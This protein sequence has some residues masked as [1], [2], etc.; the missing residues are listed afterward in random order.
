MRVAAD[1]VVLAN[2]FHALDAVK[3]Q[4]VAD[5]ID[6]GVHIAPSDVDVLNWFALSRRR[7]ILSQQ[8]RISGDFTR[9][10]V[11]ESGHILQALL[12]WLHGQKTNAFFAERYSAMEAE[13]AAATQE[14]FQ[15]AVSKILNGEVK[16]FVTTTIVSEDGNAQTFHRPAAGPDDPSTYLG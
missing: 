10:P 1:R 4:Y 5:I 15:R 11:N 6:I 3:Q 7:L 9:D 2:S 13:A 8:A 12:D 14:G 16:P